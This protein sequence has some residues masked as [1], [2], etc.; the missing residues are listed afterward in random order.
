MTDLPP[1]APT[2]PVKVPFK[3]FFAEHVG[4]VRRT[5]WRFGVAEADLDDL[6]QEVFLR[7]Y[8]AFATYDPSR[9][10]KP[11]VATFAF[12]VA[13][14]HRRL[15]YHHRERPAEEEED[16]VRATGKGPEASAATNQQLRLLQRALEML[17]DDHR[18]AFVMS[19]IYGFSGPEIAEIMKVSLNTAYSRVRLARRAVEASLQEQVVS[20]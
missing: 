18:A 1:F 19:E 17:S 15:A 6:T 7:I 10:A 14:N 20:P 12:H 3:T 9:P 8:R 2:A 11:W 13:S 16:S 5:L 4:Y